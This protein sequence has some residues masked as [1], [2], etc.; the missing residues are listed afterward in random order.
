[1][2][3][4][5][6]PLRTVDIDASPLMRGLDERQINDLMRCF[7]TDV[8]W[9][10]R[11]AMIAIDGQPQHQI[12]L[13]LSGRVQTALEEEDGSRLLIGFF[14]PGDLFGEVAALS[15]QP[16]WSHSVQAV[17]PSEILLIPVDRLLHPCACFCPAHQRF[18][19]NLIA[20]LANKA[21][22]LNRRLRFLRI[23]GMRAKLAA[24]LLE[25]A[26][27]AGARTFLIPLN[28]EELSEY[29]NVARPSMSRELGRMRDDGLI[30]F[31]RSSFTLSDVEALRKARA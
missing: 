14:G 20:V 2:P 25:E 16:V 27:Q 12:G 13:M 23:K 17:E 9:Y 21:M 15:G 22:D 31:Y 3:R 10:E 7:G 19:E 1:M 28:R 30:D 26:R 18:T 29:L 4:R 24:Y 11:G 5:T 8:R 6:S